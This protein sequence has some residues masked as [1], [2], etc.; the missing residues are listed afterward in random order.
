MANA[1]PEA[2]TSAR[3]LSGEAFINPAWLGN[4]EGFALGDV[5]LGALQA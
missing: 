2:R 4:N 3:C 1:A 5:L